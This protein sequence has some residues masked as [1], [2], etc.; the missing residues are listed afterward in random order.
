MEKLPHALVERPGCPFA[1][2]GVSD[3]ASAAFYCRLPGG[4]VRFPTP[5]DRVRFCVSGRYEECP[6]VR[7]YL[8]GR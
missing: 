3:T 6:T 8:R 5:D 2:P 4:R 1:T 7:R